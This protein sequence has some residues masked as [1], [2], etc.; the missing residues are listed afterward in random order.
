METDLRVFGEGIK[1]HG[2]NNTEDYSRGVS[3][4]AYQICEQKVLRGEEVNYE[5]VVK[6]LRDGSLRG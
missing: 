6:G 2:T 4:R 3:D 5:E 1:A